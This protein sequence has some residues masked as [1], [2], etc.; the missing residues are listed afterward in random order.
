MY[1]LLAEGKIP[2]KG[3]KNFKY[4]RFVKLSNTQYTVV[5]FLSL[6]SCNEIITHHTILLHVQ[7]SSL[8]KLVLPVKSSLSPEPT[9]QAS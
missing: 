1:A 7:V 3:L 5:G 8:L 2:Q 9:P 4:F 6:L